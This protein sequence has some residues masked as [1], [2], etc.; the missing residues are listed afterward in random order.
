VLDQHEFNLYAAKVPHY[1]IKQEL[2]N[3]Q[4]NPVF[5]LLLSRKKYKKIHYLP[6]LGKVE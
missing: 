4:S 1:K 2:P 6:N 5:L 3:L